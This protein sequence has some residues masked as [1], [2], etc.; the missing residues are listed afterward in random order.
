MVVTNTKTATGKGSDK[1]AITFSVDPNL[2]IKIKREAE[3]QGIS[4]NAKIGMIL[5][6][7]VGLYRHASEHDSIFIPE[8][9][10]AAMVDMMD[11]EK[12]L[13]LMK[14]NNIDLIPSVFLHNNIP[15]TI[16]NLIKH[17]FLGIG[18]WAG[19]YTG[20]KYY[21]DGNGS[22]N[23]VFTHDF[24][25]KWSRIIGKGFSHLIENIPELRA[26]F[27]ALPSTVT[28]QVKDI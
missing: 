3:L 22:L 28:I 15:F 16:E 2:L 23:L 25:I 19:L 27:K 13:E 5:A 9:I 4:T 24:G 7:Y 8:T 20:F 14:K 1:S 17:C 18:L 10:F 12:T 11:E 26:N 6:K 21:T